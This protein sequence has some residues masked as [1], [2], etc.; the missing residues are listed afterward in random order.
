MALWE[1]LEGGKGGQKWYNA[2]SVKNILKIK[3]KTV[4][5]ISIEDKIKNK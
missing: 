4:P 1:E 3:I 5:L 2:V